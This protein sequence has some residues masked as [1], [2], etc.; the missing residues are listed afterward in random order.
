MRRAGEGFHVK[1]G[2]YIEG[3]F[4]NNRKTKRTASKGLRTRRRGLK[5][6]IMRLL[7]G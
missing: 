6:H 4:V 7:G 5:E 3:P 1:P 2:R